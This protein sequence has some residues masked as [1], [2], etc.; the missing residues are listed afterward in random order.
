M[1]KNW[2]HAVD[3]SKV[4]GALL[5]DLFNAFDYVCHDCKIKCLWASIFSCKSQYKTIFKNANREQRMVS[6]K[7]YGKKLYLDFHKHRSWFHFCLTFFCYLFLNTEIYYFTYY[8][9]GATLLT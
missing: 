3:N 4:F 2:K 1:V 9:D 5:A 8:V 7:A 6:P